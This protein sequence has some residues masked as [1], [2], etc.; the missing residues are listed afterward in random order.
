MRNIL[1]SR[2]R[3]VQKPEL[4][5]VAGEFVRRLED[6]RQITKS[7]MARHGGENAKASTKRRAPE[8]PIPD[9]RMAILVRAARVFGIIHVHS[10]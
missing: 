5:C 8:V 7:R 10:A 4:R 6:E 9:A 2:R 3:L 1:A